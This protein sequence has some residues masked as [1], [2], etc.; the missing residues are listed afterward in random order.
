MLQANVKIIAE[1]RGFVHYVFNRKDIFSRFCQSSQ[2]FTRNRKLPFPRLVLLILKLCK[3]TLSIEL[4][5]FFEEIGTGMSCSVSAFTQ[6]RPKLKSSFFYYWNVVLWLCFYRYYSVNVKRWRGYRLIAMDGSTVSL[7]NNRALSDYFGGQSNQHSSFI[8]AQ[9]FYCYDILN[10][11]ILYSNITPYRVGELRIAWE[12][13]EKLDSDMLAIYDRNF[14]NYKTVALHMFQEQEI[15]FVIRAKESSFVRKFIASGKESSLVN[16]Q[17]GEPA[18][19][20][21][22]KAGY[23]ITKESIITVRLVRV[24]LNDKIEVLMTNLWEDEGYGTSLFKDLYFQRWAVETAIGFQ[25]NVLQM[26][27]FSGLTVHAVMQD[28]YATVFMANLHSVLKKDAQEKLDQCQNRKYPLKVNKNIS[29]SKLKEQLI[30]LFIKHRPSRVLKLL[31]TAFSLN[32][33]PV[34]KGRSFARK[35]KN[36]HTKSKYKTYTNFKPAY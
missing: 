3:K 23:I 12:L 11:L 33:L 20:G 16:L 7:V 5:K 21:M 15:K 36:S 27:S 2:D 24:E 18:I 32:P 13:I 6:Q 4:E 31:Q 10:E 22:K 17:P 25:K 34:R 28:F 9:T 8:C 29:Y 35:R 14:C 26:E 1:L 19:K 30:P